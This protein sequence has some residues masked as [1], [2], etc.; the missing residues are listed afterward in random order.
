MNVRNE[1][2]KD[3]NRTS[4]LGG[5]CDDVTILFHVIHEDDKVWDNQLYGIP[6]LL[7]LDRIDL[8]MT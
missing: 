3:L 1:N 5:R 8:P 7:A 6:Q 2:N 4:T